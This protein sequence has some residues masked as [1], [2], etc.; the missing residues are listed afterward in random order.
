[1][2]S[3][4]NDE[5][6][7][8]LTGVL[9]NFAKQYDPATTASFSGQAI[10]NGHKG[11]A[12]LLS[13]P[14]PD[15]ASKR[16]LQ[17]ELAALASRI[18]FLEAKATAA[19]LAN[20]NG[21]PITPGEP[22]FLFQQHYQLPTPSSPYSTL[23]MSTASSSYGSLEAPGNS[24]A[25]VDSG[26]PLA[27]NNSTATIPPSVPPTTAILT[28]NT[29]NTFSASTS[30]ATTPAVTPL[31]T[32]PGGTSKR[33]GDDPAQ[34]SWVSHW[35]AS[36]DGS[37]GDAQPHAVL[38]EEQLRYLKEHLNSQAEHITSQ[39][40]QIESLSAQVMRQQ[41]AQQEAFDHGFG[42]INS[43]SEELVKHQQA[44]V[45]FQK[46]LREIGTIVTAVAAGDLSKKVLIHAVEQDEEI[47]LFKK[48]INQMVDQLN[49]F[50]SEVTGLAVQV[51]TEGNLGGQAV[52]HGVQGIWKTLT[53][54]GEFLF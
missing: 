17:R 54:N 10:T 14:G 30:A 38:T 33:L 53:E 18:Q 37:N 40:E 35:L 6:L 4:D 16:A 8:L 36:P 50:A 51:G 27:I 48:T 19:S 5:T 2:M 7:V 12:A 9:S 34:Q 31:P 11:A 49:E 21:L 29:N 20:P 47:T 43:L 39:R 41:K 23:S 44:N 26:L 52:V 13:L 1:M 24:Y 22:G 46:T 15:S 45:A 28:N 42:D 25:K 3:H 32:T